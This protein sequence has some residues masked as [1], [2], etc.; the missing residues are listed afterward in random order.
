M[1]CHSDKVTSQRL[2]GCTA[3]GNGSLAKPGPHQA[4][5]RRLTPQKKGQNYSMLRNT[6]GRCLASLPDQNGTCMVFVPLFNKEP[7]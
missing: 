6:G 5:E 7:E 3:K 4:G 2:C 1:L